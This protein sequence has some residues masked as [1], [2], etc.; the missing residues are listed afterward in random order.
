MTE[1]KEHCN[2]VKGKIK[3]NNQ[4]TD[5]IFWDFHLLSFLLCFVQN[6]SGFYAEIDGAKKELQEK[7]ANLSLFDDDLVEKAMHHAQNLRRLADELD[8]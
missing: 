8:G 6:A 2:N 5:S 1:I 3:H 7:T 4:N